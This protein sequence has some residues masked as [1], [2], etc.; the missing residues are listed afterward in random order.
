MA[1]PGVTP[2]FKKRLLG[3]EE[4]DENIPVDYEHVAGDMGN[5]VFGDALGTGA[6]AK[7]LLAKVR[8][9]GGKVR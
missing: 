5:Y 7:V 3:D 4:R 1:T 8:S 6:Y 9:T 2:I